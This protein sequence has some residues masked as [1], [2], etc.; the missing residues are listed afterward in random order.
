[1][2]T[3]ALTIEHAGNLR[4]QG[5]RMETT[6]G[7]DTHEMPLYVHAPGKIRE[8]GE[9]GFKMRVGNLKHIDRAEAMYLANKARSGF[10]AWPPSECFDHEFT[11]IEIKS[12]P[13]GGRIVE[14][15]ETK[16][17]GCRWCRAARPNT[18]LQGEVESPPAPAVEPTV[19]EDSSTPPAIN[20]GVKCTVCGE[21]MTA[22][23]KNGKPRS[24]KQQLHM[25]KLHTM[26]RHAGE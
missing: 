2:V 19:G 4:R 9:I 12:R 5:Y 11:P 8:V 26:R 15:S 25:L 3:Q 22:V 7:W 14:R 16:V 6:F 21:V 18:G 17:F 1:M 20:E 23:D 10:F 24:K 13:G